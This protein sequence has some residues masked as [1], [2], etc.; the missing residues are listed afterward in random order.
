MQAVPARVTVITFPP[1]LDSAVLCRRKAQVCG[2]IPP[3]Q[4]RDGM[5]QL[6]QMS[7]A[8]PSKWALKDEG[9]QNWTSVPAYTES[10]LLT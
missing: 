9:F 8:V 1:P 10:A 3:H 2:L 4:D 5:W 7:R 6:Q